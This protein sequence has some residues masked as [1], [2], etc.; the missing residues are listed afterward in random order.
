MDSS[1]NDAEPIEKAAVLDEN[2]SM[3]FEKDQ[4]LSESQ[5]LVSQSED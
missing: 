5:Q 1:L 4:S 3:S 2:Q